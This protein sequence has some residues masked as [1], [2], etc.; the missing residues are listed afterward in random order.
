MLHIQDLHKTSPGG[1]R[2][3]AGVTL[4]LED[5][6]RLV[7]LMAGTDSASPKSRIK[8][9]LHATGTCVALRKSPCD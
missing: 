5:G 4:R 8:P 3:L 7:P 1:R 6:E 9:R 2:A